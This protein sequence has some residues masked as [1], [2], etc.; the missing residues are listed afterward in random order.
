MSRR[1]KVQSVFL[2]LL[3]ETNPKQRFIIISNLTKTQLDTLSEVALNIYK[4]IFPN[5]QTYVEALKPYR[6]PM[7]RL[8]SKY[9]QQSQKKT[10]LKRYN[11]IIPSLLRP[12]FGVFIDM[13]K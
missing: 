11:K 10:L 9:V 6:S 13:S 2:K 5:T 12:V 8:G 4:G 3:Y 7:Y 1:K